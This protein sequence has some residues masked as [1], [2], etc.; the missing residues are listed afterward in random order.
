MVIKMDSTFFDVLRKSVP[1]EKAKTGEKLDE[2]EYPEDVQILIDILKRFSRNDDIDD[3]KIRDVVQRFNTQIVPRLDKLTTTVRRAEALKD[4]LKRRLRFN[5]LS[6]GRYT[7]AF[8]ADDDEFL[9]YN[10]KPAN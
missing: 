7:D 4:P 9:K 5:V 6:N 3:S 1:V 8:L 2:R 10:G